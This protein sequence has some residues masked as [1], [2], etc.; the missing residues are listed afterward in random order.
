[1]VGQPL[2]DEMLAAQWNAVKIDGETFLLDVFWASTCLEDGQQMTDWTHLWNLFDEGNQRISQHEF[3][4][5]MHL[6]T[7]HQINEFFFLTDPEKFIVTHLPENDKWQLLPKPLSREEFALQPFIRERF[8]DMKLTLPSKQQ[9]CTIRAK[10]GQATYTLEADRAD[11]KIV[12]RW[13]LIRSADGK[14]QQL[15]VTSSYDRYVF[16]IKKPASVDFWVVFPEAGTYLLDLYGQV[17]TGEHFAQVC[18]LCFL[19]DEASNAADPLPD[20]PDCGWGLRSFAASDHELTPLFEDSPYLEAENGSLELRFKVPNHKLIGFSLRHNTIEDVVLRKHALVIRR[21]EVVSVQMRLPGKGSY[22]L[23]IYVGE[24]TGTSMS[25]VANYMVN[26]VTAGLNT[27][28]FPLLYNGS[29]GPEPMMVKKFGISVENEN[30]LL[31]SNDG[32]VQLTF[33]ID[34]P[35]SVDLLSELQMNNVDSSKLSSY[36]HPFK[37]SSSVT[38]ELQLPVQGEYGLNVF[39]RKMG[40]DYQ[41]FHVYS[42]I[43]VAES[44]TGA[45]VKPPEQPIATESIFTAD[46]I[47]DIRVTQS[48]GALVSVAKKN[49]QNRFIDNQITA[50]KEGEITVYEVDLPTTGEYVVVVYRLK[51][52]NLVARQ[53]A[54]MVRLEPL[55]GDTR[56]MAVS[57]VLIQFYVHTCKSCTVLL[58][59]RF[60]LL[61]LSQMMFPDRRLNKLERKKRKS[62]SLGKRCILQG[63]SLKCVLAIC[64]MARIS[65]LVMH[66]CMFSSRMLFL[67]GL[68]HEAFRLQLRAAVASQNVSLLQWA[69]NQCEMNYIPEKNGELRKSKK[70][71]DFMM[72]N[73]GRINKIKFFC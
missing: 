54:Q 49:S 29:L 14:G 65:F 8:Y 43:I 32:T 68:N 17:G 50:K 30:Y 58:L 70:I 22:A 61:S 24:V 41:I 53:V 19:V 57:Q 20:L 62:M 27:K 37:E 72:C 67:E 5:D 9:S 66:V 34:D 7:K 63:K 15:N 51:G 40:I 11:P 60:S 55:Q 2:N 56:P 13:K 33:E 21:D 6:R 46:D 12:F 64:V 69:I 16:Y 28:A 35:K 42:Y 45:P 26:C 38:F 59:L 1:M 4:P 39:A 47:A 25:N 18:S 73:Q 31:K 36:L 3:N 10:N 52:G 48:K 23:G 71:L 44:G